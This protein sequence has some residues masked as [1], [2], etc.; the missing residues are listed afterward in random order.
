TPGRLPAAIVAAH[1]QNAKVTGH[2]CSIGFREAAGLGIDDLEHGLIVD[3]EFF[4]EKKQGECPDVADDMVRYG[5]M[6][7]QT[8]PVHDMILDLIKHHVA[9][10]STLPV[11]E[12][13]VTGRPVMQRRVLDAL[14]AEARAR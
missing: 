12:E 4:P 7:V 5:K 11:F 1:K 9:V 14:T 13:A 10:T 8:G 3:T 2:L 6:G